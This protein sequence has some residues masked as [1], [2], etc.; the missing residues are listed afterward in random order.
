M[1]KTWHIIKEII[2]VA[3][4][5]WIVIAAGVAGIT[6]SWKLISHLLGAH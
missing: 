2:I 1:K 4:L 6:L 5:L 3:F